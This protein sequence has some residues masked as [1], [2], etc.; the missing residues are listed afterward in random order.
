MR[1]CTM[2]CKPS[3]GGW[4]RVVDTALPSP[5]DIADPGHEE[6]VDG[7]EYRVVGHSVVVLVSSDR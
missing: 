2:I 3:G 1:V 6:A 5:R 7:R 4:L